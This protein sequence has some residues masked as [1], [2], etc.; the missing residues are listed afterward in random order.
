MGDWLM[1]GK[2]CRPGIYIGQREA[3]KLE[4][5]PAGS[6]LVGS[7]SHSPFPHRISKNES[8]GNRR[9]ATVSNGRY[10]W[11]NRHA[12]CPTDDEK[13]FPCQPPD[14]EIIACI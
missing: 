10:G 2:L 6:F 4:H 11:A 8:A 1:E 5:R 14:I 9:H 3:L 7:F 12:P 13:N